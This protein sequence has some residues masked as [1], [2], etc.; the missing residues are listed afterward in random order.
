MQLEVIEEFRLDR[1]LTEDTRQLLA[2]CFPDE[3]FKTRTYGVQTPP[4][5]LLAT[6]GSR[7]VGHVGLE[8]R[9]V[10]TTTGTATIFGLID[11]GVK[12]NARRQGIASRMLEHIDGLAVDHGIEFLV[13]FARDSRLY[14][15]HG[16]Q[17][18]PNPVRWTWIEE[19]KSVGVEEA[20]IEGLMVK[21]VSARAWPA[22][23][24]DLLGYLF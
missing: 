15:R 22:G 6:E 3:K 20:P 17:Y 19:R 10:G 9:V 16:Y 7:L 18:V 5:R 23:C 11:V 13:L 21:A 24:I 12:A 1:Q 2:E 14:E 4:R 8:H